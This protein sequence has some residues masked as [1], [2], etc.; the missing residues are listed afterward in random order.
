MKKCLNI[1]FLFLVSNYLFGQKAEEG[2]TYTFGKLSQEPIEQMKELFPTRARESG[3]TTFTVYGDASVSLEMYFVNGSQYDNIFNPHPT[4]LYVGG[5]EFF[6]YCGLEKSIRQNYSNIMMSH[7]F[8][9]LGRSYLLLINFRE[10]CMGA[11]CR[12][13]CYNLFDITEPDQVM[14]TSF[15]TLFEGITT[16]GEFNNDGII[17][18]VRVAP[19]SPRDQEPGEI[20]DH[21]LVTAYTLRRG[22]PKQLFNNSGHAYYLFIKGDEAVN[23]FEVLKSDWFY[24]VRD[25]SGTIAKPVPYFAEYISFDPLYRH[26]YNPDGIRVEK[27][28]FSI[29]IKDLGDLEA[30]QEYCRRIQNDEVSDVYIMIDQY[31]GEINFQIMV[32]NYMSKDGASSMLAKLQQLGY[33][34]TLIDFR[35]SY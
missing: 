25:T 16:F 3:D 10:D 9:Y 21:Y 5:K 13:R 32:G 6:F 27:N 12:Y 34:G 35:K 28:R 30:A 4:G 18:F 17:D 15:S 22:R 33:N 2:G 31:S 7:E 24:S 8:Y 29:H 14:Q 23:E 26:L 1:I 11:G 19:K 20:I